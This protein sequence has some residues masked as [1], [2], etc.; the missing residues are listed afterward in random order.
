MFRRLRSVLWHIANGFSLI[1]S[2]HGTGTS[3][4]VD[5]PG[6]VATAIAIIVIASIAGLAFLGITYARLASLSLRAERLRAENEKLRVEQHKIE[7]IRREIARIEKMRQ[8]IEL[9][10]GIAT[11]EGEQG[12]PPEEKQSEATHLLEPNTWPRKY[13]YALLKP[14]YEG[15]FL[16]R[17]GMVTPVE[18]FLSRTFTVDAEGGAVHPGIDIAAATGTPV[19]CALDGKV[20][21]AGWDDVYGN[22][23]I[24][25]HGDSLMTVY[26]HNEKLLVKEGDHV[27][28][29]E[30]IATVGSTG[31]STAPHLHF[32]V[33]KNG[34]PVDPMQFVSLNLK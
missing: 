26:G 23:V 5:V 2:P 14:F 29:G 31:R 13:T 4:T 24:V 11:Q 34:K 33:M 28:T 19:R 18:G 12:A 3:I 15:Q 17:K 30:V 21:F 6:R 7:E 10:A 9:W 27:T 8:Q 22:L 16:V 25:D 1:I 32:G 20:T